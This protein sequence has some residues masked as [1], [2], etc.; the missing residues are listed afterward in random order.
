MKQLTGLINKTTSITALSMITAF[1]AMALPVAPFENNIWKSAS[2]DYMVDAQRRDADDMSCVLFI[3]SQRDG[4]NNNIHI[5]LNED[6][7]YNTITRYKTI[8]SRNQGFGKQHW[9]EFDNNEDAIISW[10]HRQAD[11]ID[12]LLE[13]LGNAKTIT[14]HEK[15]KLPLVHEAKTIQA[16]VDMRPMGEALKRFAQCRQHLKMQTQKSVELDE[17]KFKWVSEKGD[18]GVKYTGAFPTLFTNEMMPATCELT[19]GE[20]QVDGIQLSFEQTELA[21][22]SRMITGFSY[23]GNTKSGVKLDNGAIQRQFPT[24]KQLLNH[25]SITLYQKHNTDGKKISHTVPLADFK[26]AYQQQQA[27]MT[28]IK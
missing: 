26:E 20:Y 24:M 21:T 15:T 23:D 10:N 27:C 12:E 14:M 6:M 7:T 17:Q 22:K 3:R 5:T 4:N 8:D 1:N 18:I 28:L 25:Q 11:G 2:E 13:Q 16:S 9:I 19:L